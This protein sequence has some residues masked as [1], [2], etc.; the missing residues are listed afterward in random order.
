LTHNRL[1]HGFCELGLL[2]VGGVDQSDPLVLLQLERVHEDLSKVGGQLTKGYACG[3]V[4]LTLVGIGCDPG[5]QPVDRAE[6][7]CSGDRKY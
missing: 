4:V 7:D 3:E 1:R 5:A 6:S 2:Q